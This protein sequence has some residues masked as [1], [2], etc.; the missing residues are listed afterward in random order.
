MILQGFLQRVINGGGDIIRE[1]A[2]G[3]KR[4]DICIVYEGKKYP[5]ELKIWRNNK[6]LQE[7]LEQTAEYMDIF[8]CSEGWLVFFNRNPEISWDEKIYY[9][10]ENVGEKVINVFGN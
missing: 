9:R 1:P 6:S 8:G 3:R 2:S 7:G 5:I 10:K 4:T